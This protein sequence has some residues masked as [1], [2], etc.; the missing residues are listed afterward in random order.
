MSEHI[1][2]DGECGVCHWAVAFVARRDTGGEIFRF[3]PLGGETFISTVPEDQQHKL[4]DSMIVRTRQGELLLRSVGVVHILRRLG[5]FW[6]FLGSLLWL[7]PRP[8][9]DLG[10]DG[11]AAIR[12]RLTRQPEGVCPMVPPEI[13]RRFDP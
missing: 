2:Y 7:V 9:R 1:F 12:A 5:G 8:L 4:P 13:G 11:F 10:Y 6:G 3:A